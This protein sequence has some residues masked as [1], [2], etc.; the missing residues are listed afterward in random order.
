MSPI[1]NTSPRKPSVMVK[2]LW[3]HIGLDTMT[4]ITMFKGSLPPIIAI[5][6]YQ[7][8]AFAKHF[9]TLGY[10]VAIASILGFCIMPRGKFIMNMALEVI[11]ICLGAAVNLL[12]LFCAVKARQSTTPAGQPLSGYNSSASAVLAIWLIVQIYIVNALRAAKP[13]FQ[14]PAIIYTIFVAVSS[15]YGTQFPD[16]PASVSFMERLMEAFFTGFA[17]AVGVHFVIFPISSRT[18]LLKEMTGYMA[19][20]NGILKAQ[21]A[22]MD[23]LIDL[24]PV[25]A[26]EE[27]EH[28][29]NSE[30][31]NG[32]TKG[33]LPGPLTTPAAVQLRTAVN[34]LMSL[35]TKIHGDIVPAKREFAY[36]KLESHD[37]TSLWKHCQAINVPI[38]GLSATLELLQ[39]R[40][41]DA[42]WAYKAVTPS[43]Q[44]TRGEELHNLKYLMR[45]M[46]A[47]VAKMGGEIQK[48]IQ[49][50]LVILELVKIPKQKAR[51]E[52]ENGNDLIPGS[53]TFMESYAKVVKNYHK[54][55]EGTLE[56]WCTEHDID[57]PT[58]YFD[59][60]F[61][62]QADLH[63]HDGE[64]TRGSQRQLFF[65]LYLEYLLFRASEAVLDCI[66]FAERRKSEG[67]LKRHKLIFPGSRTLY[68]WLIS[69]FGDE[70]M[71]QDE[72]FMADMDSGGS[73]SVY[74]GIDFGSRKD[75]E[76]LPPRST[77]EKI[78]DR[79][80]SLPR[81]LRSDA[82][83]F[84]ELS[85]KCSPLSD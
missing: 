60:N 42:N 23:S 7:S 13:Q 49:H 8:Q 85:L 4:V 50:I 27:A 25:A 63:L 62:G 67:A 22:F 68:K 1:S 21:G 56:D 37:L 57:I 55:K 73:Q 32:K 80:R 53:A 43:Q 44:E 76:H 41:A 19:G 36:G 82:S 30:R 79:I 51:D 58:G 65:A 2:K 48:G 66:A 74:L 38:N 16:M 31:H 18:V 26:R 75:P 40:A 6:A 83:A 5:A 12:A 15:T 11:A 14:F 3:G 71:S 45:E 54:S 52:E 46:R 69:A 28:N 9:S 34:S 61:V 10:L 81:F 64:K 78:G 17:I 59:E 77:A 47:P 72:H 39:R 35:H 20:L 29:E 33:P 70:D 24:D 84:G